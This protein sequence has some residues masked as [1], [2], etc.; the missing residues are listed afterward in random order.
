MMDTVKIRIE[1]ADVGEKRM[2]QNFRRWIPWRVPTRRSERAILLRFFL[3][4][5]FLG[6]VK[7]ET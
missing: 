6:R 3:L 7:A 4:V 2:V 1:L 5:G